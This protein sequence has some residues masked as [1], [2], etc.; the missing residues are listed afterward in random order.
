[1]FKFLI[2]NCFNVSSQK[3]LET[4]FYT[5]PQFTPPS[6]IAYANIR[7]AAYNIE[8]FKMNSLCT[9]LKNMIDVK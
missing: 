6:T 2:H 7:V 4:A 3:C 8:I 9:S 5:E 1:M